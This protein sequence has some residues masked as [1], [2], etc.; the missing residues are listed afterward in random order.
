MTLIKTRARGLKLDDTFAFT[1]TVSGAGGGKIGQ[2]QSASFASNISTSSTSFTTSGITDTITLSATD[3][4]VL[5]LVNGG[6]S[7]YGGGECEGTN[8]LYYK[9]GSGSDSAI[10]DI[11]VGENVQSGGYAKTPCSFNYLHSPST[12]SLLTYTVYFK[13]NANTYYL[14]SDSSPINITLMEVLA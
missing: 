10:I 1:G 2:V 8:K 14:S 6:R 11:K 12:T 4:K 9:V 3:S 5:I 7:S 13:T